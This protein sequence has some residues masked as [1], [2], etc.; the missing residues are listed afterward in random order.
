MRLIRGL[1]IR[2]I[3]IHGILALSMAGVLGPVSAQQ[4]ELEGPERGNLRALVV[5]IDAYKNVRPL[6]G[7]IADA[8]DIERALRRSGVGDVTTL[9]DEGVTR[10]SVIAALEA[11]VGR[12]G[13]GDFVIL[14]IAGHGAQEP[15]RVRG[16]QPDGMDTI[17][18][19]TNFARSVAGSRERI[20]GTEF[21]HFIRRLEEKGATVLFIADTCHGGGMTRDVDPRAGEL[22]YR[23]VPAYQIPNDALVPVSTASEAFLTEAD[24]ERSAFLAA[25]DRKTKAP[26]IV[27]PGVA[28]HRGALSYAVAR[29][30]EGA[31][32][33]NADGK[34]TLKELFGYV[35]QVVYQLSDQRQNPV[36]VS[37]PHRDV[38]HDVAFGLSRGVRI[39]DAPEIKPT[40]IASSAA[41][42]AP[43]AAAPAPSAATKAPIGE[44]VRVAAL[45]GKA[46]WFEGLAPREAPFEV[47]LPSRGPDLIWDAAS[48]DLLA[49]AD[50]IAFRLDKADLPSAIDR[51][52]AV[53]ALKTMAAQWPQA[54]RVLPDDSLR[55]EGSRA[56]VE[57]A[58]LQG[59]A[60]ILL[61]IAGDGTVQMLH[62]MRPDAK[63]MRDAEFRVPV[64]VRRPYGADLVVA[65]S[66][67]QPL[68]QLEQALRA[69]NQ[70][71]GA[72]EALR[73]VERYRS[74]GLR[75]GAAGIF[76]AP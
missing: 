27:I 41:V 3:L 52:A 70:R 29:A 65:I 7:A 24:F 16:S 35:R 20:V 58:N 11:L 9:V 2:G 71:R 46:A 25:V 18:L 43:P 21:N 73:L 51:A 64:Q 48:G 1:L 66:S 4:V 47:V 19:L 37:S 76:T 56:F 17:F 57:V 60:L 75:I 44:R 72:V 15:E 28:G 34:V 12:A 40:V 39:V 38:E 69:L 45:D 55:R 6:L 30:L 50:V 8:R 23:Q 68:P 22:S 36:T 63:P 42:P 33:A 26:E 61:N 31:A 13:Q 14:S 54:V 74:P 53:R 10:D 32:D 49:G 62:P 59:R 5:G 67:E